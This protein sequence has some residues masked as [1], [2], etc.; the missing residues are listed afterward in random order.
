MSRKTCT[1]CEEEL[2]I[3]NFYPQQQRGANG[4]VWKYFDSM[5]KSCRSQYTHKRRKQNKQK[6]IEY[7]GG[8]CADCEIIDDQVIYDF[9]HLDP[10]QKDYSFG[11][12]NLSFEKM[13]VELDK[14]ILLCS[15]CHRKRHK[16]NAYNE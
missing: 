5:C 8:L 14:C 13:K 12:R 2:L 1:R 7:L 9:H 11:K 6:A 16:I 3:E 15:N 10:T 4:Q